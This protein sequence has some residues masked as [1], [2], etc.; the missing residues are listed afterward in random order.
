MYSSG[1]FIQYTISSLSS[2]FPSFLKDHYAE[3]FPKRKLYSRNNEKFYVNEPLLHAQCLEYGMR[4][5]VP[6]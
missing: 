2:S 1:N 3:N 4:S 5:N 6:S